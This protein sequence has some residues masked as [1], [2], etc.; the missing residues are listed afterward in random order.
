[1]KRPADVVESLFGQLESVEHALAECEVL[2]STMDP[3]PNSMYA[4]LHN[5]AD[6]LRAEARSL[7]DRIGQVVQSSSAAALFPIDILV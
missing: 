2:I 3:Q 5:A 6:V 1:M 4:E 7:A